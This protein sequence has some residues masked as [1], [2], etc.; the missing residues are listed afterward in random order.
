M[1]IARAPFFQ[2]RLVMFRCAGNVQAGEDGRRHPGLEQEP[3]RFRHET[4]P[5]HGSDYGRGRRNPP[6][7][8]RE[9]E[10]G[11][12]IAEARAP[13]A[14]A[15]LDAA[16]LVHVEGASEDEARAHLER[17]ALMSPE[18]AA[19]SVRFVTDPTWRA[20]SVTYAAG[21]ELCRAY[22]AGE[23]SRFARLLTE[24]V[25]VAELLGTA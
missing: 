5:Q 8:T 24:Q 3:R 7:E 9:L 6:C 13:L 11:I 16:L 10:Q 20:Y 1:N 21:R 17:W 12:A 4:V 23:R 19:N 25:T 18:R 22:V 15:S 2:Q 14:R